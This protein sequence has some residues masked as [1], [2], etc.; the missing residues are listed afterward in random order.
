MRRSRLL[1]VLVGALA[2]GLSSGTART[3]STVGRITL[4]DPADR[5][6]WPRA[7][8]PVA[9]ITFQVTDP[10]QVPGT[11]KYVI[12]VSANGLDISEPDEAYVLSSSPTSYTLDPCMLTD[13]NDLPG[14]RIKLDFE[15]SYA[16]PVD[17]LVKLGRAS[18]TATVTL[19]P[20]TKGPRL[21]IERPPSQQHVRPGDVVEITLRA[22]EPGN[23]GVWQTGVRRFELLKPNGRLEEET[24]SKG[25]ARAC[26][27]KVRTG[28]ATFDYRVPR[29]AQAGQT[30]NFVA[31]AFD[32]AGNRSERRLT[33]IVGEERWTG[34]LRVVGT[35]TLPRAGDFLYRDTAVITFNFTVAADG[36]IM[37]DGTATRTP[38]GGQDSANGC[39]HTYAPTPLEFPV[40]ISGRKVGKDFELNVSAPGTGTHTASAV[41]RG[42]A[43]PTVTLET[44]EGGRLGYA[45]DIRSRPIVIEA[46]DGATRRVHRRGPSDVVDVA[47]EIEIFRQRPQ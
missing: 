9:G 33:L 37:G 19:G 24:V 6:L 39:T 13:P 26:G 38:E 47:A 27:D 7:D 20:D 28:K 3:Q 1:V 31:T 12:T 22:E 21:T 23:V 17:N 42:R 30:L 14:T 18:N 36:A 16:G 40:E 35:H 34:S 25:G 41:C 5:I 15:V 44:K 43:L 29:D 32:W 8:A 2:V 11:G 46:E 10:V 45:G 4:A